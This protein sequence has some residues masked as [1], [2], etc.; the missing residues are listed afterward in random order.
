MNTTFMQPFVS[1]T[2]AN[3]WTISLNTESSYDWAGEPDNGPHGW[4][5]RVVATL[6]PLVV[7]GLR[8]AG[9]GLAVG[10]IAAIATPAGAA[11]T[12][13]P[14][15]T[16]YRGGDILTMAGPKPAYAEAL[17][18]KG[19]RIL[20][21]GPLAGAI[22]AAGGGARQ[23]NLAGRTLLPGFIDAHGHLV[24]AS[25]TLLNA[26]L[27][28]VKSIPELLGRMKAHAATLP[29]GAMV[30]GLGYR[31]EQL[32]E[33]R[34]P[35]KE[36]LDSVSTSRPVF[37]QDGS[38]HQG[39]INSVL[40]KQ[41]G[42][43][44]SSKDPAGGVISRKPGSN[45]PSGH[46]AEAPVFA[47]LAA[48]APLSPAQIRLGVDKAVALWTAN[49]QTTASEMGFGLSDDDI[50]VA[51]QMLNEKLLP[52]DLLLFVKHSF[53]EQAKAGRKAVMTQYAN[54]ASRAPRVDGDERYVNRVRLA[55]VKFWLDGSMD[56]AF[57][58]QPYTNNPPGNTEKNFRGLAVDPQSAV[59]STVATYWK[60][61]RQVA[62]HSIGDQAVD[63]FLTAIEKAYASQGPADHR[64]IIQHA[65]FLR[66]DQIV[67]ANKV[68]AITSFTAG[69][70]YP[71]GD[72]L[73]RLM[74]PDRVAWA[75]A[76]GSVQ[77]AGIPWTMHHDMPAGVSP[78][79]IY[80]LWN[81]VNRTTKSG[82]VLAPQEKVSPYDGLR[83]L[84][85]NGA[86]QF[87]EEKSKGSL[88]PGKL[89]DLVVLSANP[90]KVDPMTIKDIQVVE[91]IKE[92]TSLYRNPSVTSGGAST[93]AAPINEKDNC[94]VPHDHPQKPLT[95]AQQ[96]TM[97][98]LLAPGP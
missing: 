73:A 59:E 29:E 96:A 8:A 65:Q 41:M 24:L 85:I 52:I 82:V 12:T 10:L 17:V 5:A 94:L 6:P 83:A 45:E 13:Q 3:A 2:T 51:R 23:V 60:S 19:G 28:G 44:A 35:T 47:V 15:A 74:G 39:S 97:D 77:R 38:G 11:P 53:L 22:K 18:E 9:L 30:E 75:G 31:A 14:A 76:A 86:Y 62:G 49:G 20:Y 98:R 56:N 92:G 84:T 36:E 91:T 93:A 70:I 80:A 34:H 88:E 1:Y 48:K 33:N 78:S 46:I 7:P 32:A 57:M 58:S 68:G 42:W 50:D 27:I 16:L 71:M 89:A 61:N 81:I 95:S 66:P 72:Y 79:L 55:G 69:G 26:E 64:P 43:N 40:L 67:R 54:P 63:N 37:V 87:H 90:L 21:V 4:G 25:H